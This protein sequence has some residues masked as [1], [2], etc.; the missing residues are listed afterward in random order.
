MK[1]V[2]LIFD[3]SSHARSFSHIFGASFLRYDSSGRL[4]AKR[5]CENDLRLVGFEHPL[6]PDHPVFCLGDL[7]HILKRVR[8]SLM[9]DKAYLFFAPLEAELHELCSR[10]QTLYPHRPSEEFDATLKQFWRYHSSRVGKGLYEEILGAEDGRF[11]SLSR[12]TLSCI[13]L[14]SRT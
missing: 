4:W 5:T 11:L 3:G 12:L 1:I 8:N 14:T 6:Q 9:K 7:I 2:A 13:H 10:I